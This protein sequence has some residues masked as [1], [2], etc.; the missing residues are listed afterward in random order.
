M[1]AKP[2]KARQVYEGSHGG[3]TRS[4]CS[5]LEK[6]GHFGKIAA[7]LFRAQKASARA[8]V[9][10]GGIKNSYGNRISYRTLAYSRKGEC[11]SGLC[12]LLK[13]DACGLTWG[14]GTD[15]KQPFAVHVLYVDLPQGQVSLHSTKRFVGSDYAGQ[16]DG[17]NRSEQRILWFCDRIMARRKQR[18]RKA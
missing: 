6:T 5:A 9:Y 15:E 14:W 10:R 1:E 16:W 12:D 7:Q 18:R 11:L 2:L 13:A 17:Q 8:K 3:Q 4:F